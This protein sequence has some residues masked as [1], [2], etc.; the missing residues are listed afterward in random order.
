[1][2]SLHSS[3]IL[4]KMFEQTILSLFLF[5]WQMNSSST[6]TNLKSYNTQNLKVCDYSVFLK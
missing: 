1:M 2:I 3:A 5:L 4:Q 6:K